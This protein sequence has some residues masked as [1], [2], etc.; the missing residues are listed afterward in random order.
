MWCVAELT[1][2][3]V[4][5]MEDFWKTYERP[6][7]PTEPVV[8]VDEKPVTL[9]ADIR[10]PTRPTG[11]GSPAR[12]RVR[13]MQDGQCFLCG[14]TQSRPFHQP[15]AK[16]FGIRVHQSSLLALQCPGAPD[17]SFGDG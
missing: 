17:H 11:I 6:Y 15:H 4:T 2:D 7:N 13:A 1:E 5:K 9:Q 10:P 16:P 14:G 3:F 8:F 12:E